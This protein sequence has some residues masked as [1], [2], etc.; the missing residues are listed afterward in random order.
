L[1]I[2]SNI[3]SLDVLKLTN[4]LLNL[5]HRNLISAKHNFKTIHSIIRLNFLTNGTS[6]LLGIRY[7]VSF[8][9]SAVNSFAF[10]S[11]PYTCPSRSVLLQQS[12]QKKPLINRP[13]LLPLHLHNLRASISARNRRAHLIIN[14][15]GNSATLPSPPTLTT[16]QIAYC[17]NPLPHS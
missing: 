4:I 2:P 8:M 1:G 5:G 6:Y 9:R 7:Q 3:W 10:Q 16:F 12:K 13:T 15:P 14:A 17:T 11:Q